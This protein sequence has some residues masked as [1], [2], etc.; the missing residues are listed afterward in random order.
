VDSASIL[1]I[2]LLTASA[3][4]VFIFIFL[5]LRIK[6]KK[7]KEIVSESE[8]SEIRKIN[9][10]S[11]KVG[12]SVSPNQVEKA[13]EELRI[14]ELEREILSDAI[15]KLYEAHAEG[16]IS[17]AERDKLLAHYRNR[18][19]SVK[20]AIE[21]NQSVVALHELEAMQED[22]IKLFNE[23]FGEL[24]RKIEEL[25]ARVQVTAVKEIKPIKI[26]P[27]APAERESPTKPVAKRKGK[28]RRERKEAEAKKSAAERRIEEIKAEIERVL[29]RLGQMEVEA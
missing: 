9:F 13:R 10:Q 16:K 29:A 15:R 5:I 8:P 11:L 12:R 21:K 2:A 6:S 24:S 27:P 18:M 28:K 20:E 7:E 23:R 3:A 26:A 17:E 19:L 22:L 4:A 25:R 14:L 1:M